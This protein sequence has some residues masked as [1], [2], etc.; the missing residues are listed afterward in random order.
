[1]QEFVIQEYADVDDGA[2]GFV[3]S[4]ND[5]LT[6]EGYIDMMSGTDLSG[7]QNAITE[8]STHILIIP[9]YTLGITDAMRV[10]D[11]DKRYY[12]I[13]YADDPVGQQHHNELYLK[14]GGVVSA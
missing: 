3:G 8:E 2:G 7:I 12:T 5:L 1:M 13:T 4:W 11:K 14:Y 10:V 6:V 9:A